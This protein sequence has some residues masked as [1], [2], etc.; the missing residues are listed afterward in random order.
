[1]TLFSKE[2]G[3]GDK[4]RKKA[5]LEG[6]K[7]VVELEAT[8]GSLTS[9]KEE[10]AAASDLVGSLVMTMMKTKRRLFSACGK[11]GLLAQPLGGLSRRRPRRWRLRCQAKG[12]RGWLAWP[13]MGR[14][15]TLTTGCEGQ[16]GWPTEIGGHLRPTEEEGGIEKGIQGPP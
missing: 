13:A 10:A 1:V 4:E 12:V 11:E 14:A 8:F 3:R 2:G 6:E 9:S 16:A 15:N 5:S 7:D